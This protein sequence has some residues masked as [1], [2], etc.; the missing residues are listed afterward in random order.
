MEEYLRLA[1]EELYTEDGLTV[2]AKGVG[3]W[4][5]LM[6]FVLLYG[7]QPHSSTSEASS[8]T[9]SSAAGNEKKLVFCL[10]TMDRAEEMKKCLIYEGLGPAEFP[11]VTWLC[12]KQ[13]CSL[14]DWCVCS[15]LRTKRWLMRE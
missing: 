15:L 5:V 4:V 8:S 11:K 14:T 7:T 6:K 10:Q 12:C 13:C 1:F 3:V 9:S 2:M